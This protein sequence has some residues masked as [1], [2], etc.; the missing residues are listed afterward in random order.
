M[1]VV[2]AQYGGDY[3][4]DCAALMV[5]SC[6]DLG[7]HV[8]QLTDT[9][10]PKVDGVD[11]AIRRQRNEGGMLFRMRHLAD[12]EPPYVMLDPD[13]LV[14]KDLADGFSDDNDVSLTFRAVSK[15]RQNSGEVLDMPYN[16]GVVF[17]RNVE[18]V[19]DC[20]A[21][22]LK[23]PARHQD[24]Y[25]DQLALRDVAKSGQYMVRE[26]DEKQWNFV[27]ETTFAGIRNRNVRIYHFKGLR[28]KWMT[29]FD[30]H[31]RERVA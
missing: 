16:G 5:R 3:H 29:D 17:V 1:R 15:V 21:A 24:W 6:K 11:E 9:W 26:L 30:K 12:L 13:M 18:F 2:F 7:Y 19:R 23:M 10:T 28:K 20:L 4:L 31:L 8:T 14:A 27:P 22:M 25:G